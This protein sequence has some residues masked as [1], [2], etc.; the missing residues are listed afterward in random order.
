[1]DYFYLIFAVCWPISTFRSRTHIRYLHLHVFQVYFCLKKNKK[2]NTCRRNLATSPEKDWTAPL[3]WRL[4]LNSI[5]KPFQSILRSAQ[6]IIHVQLLL[7]VQIVLRM[8][9]ADNIQKRLHKVSSWE[10]A[11]L[12]S[13]K[14]LWGAR[15]VEQ[16]E[17]I[18]ILGTTG[19]LA[20]IQ[21]WELAHLNRVV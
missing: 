2:K 21:C 20:D 3:T 8:E 14:I 9:V 4:Q 7:L 1:M 13:A 18:S 12:V 11:W 6:N 10:T 17:T 5:A 15:R 16:N 19:T